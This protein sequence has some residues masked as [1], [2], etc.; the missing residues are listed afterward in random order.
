[1][2]FKFPYFSYKLNNIRNKTQSV[3]HILHTHTRTT[4]PP[5]GAGRDY[6]TPPATHLTLV[7]LPG[8]FVRTS[9]SGS[10]RHINFSKVKCT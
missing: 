1:M 7:F 2:Y 6:G 8:L 3:T 4:R 10:D 5:T 9:Q